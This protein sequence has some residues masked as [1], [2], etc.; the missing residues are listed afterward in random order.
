MT[1]V[2]EEAWGVRESWEG[3]MGGGGEKMKVKEWMIWKE[4]KK[5]GQNILKERI[6][7]TIVIHSIETRM[8]IRRVD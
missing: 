2:R 6:R 8:D 3:E 7:K 5:Y 4:E 1:K